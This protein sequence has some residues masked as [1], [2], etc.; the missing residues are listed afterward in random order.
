MRARLLRLFC[1]MLAVALPL[2]LA[3]CDDRA[4]L[5]PELDARAATSGPTVNAPSG[6]NAVA[7]SWSQINLSWQDNSSN[8]S[9]FEVHRSTSGPSGAFTLLYSTAANVTSYS[10]GGLSGSTQYCYKVRASRTAGGKTSYS[11]FS[12]TACATTPVSPLPA[13]PSAVHAAPFDNWTI[14]ITWTDNSTNEAGF[15]V[16]RGATTSGPWTAAFT[17]D[18][19]TTGFADWTFAIYEQAVCYRVFAVNRYGDSN[20][21]NVSCTAIPYPPTNLTATP[22]AGP[23]V[24]LAWTDNSAVEDGVEVL[25]ATSGA[26]WSTIARLPANATAYHDASTALDNTYA[27]AVRATKDGGSSSP[28]NSVQVVMPATKLPAAPSGLGVQPTSSSSVYVTWTDQSSNETGFRVERSTDGGASWVPVA[29]TGVDESSFN[30]QAVSAEQQV[31]YRAIAFNSIGDSPPSNTACTTAPA[32]PTNL[33]GIVRDDGTIEVRWTDNSAVEDGYEVWAL[34]YSGD[35]YLLDIVP[36]NTTSYIL[37]APGYGNYV[38]AT[39]DG[40]HSDPSNPWP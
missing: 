28:S 8:E 37:P 9:G 33:T 11:S 2:Y 35:Y 32:G 25:R 39:K 6:T 30:D 31:C 16:E 15:R 5:A 29:S 22:V 12:N 21:S 27:Y 26:G 24:D 13:T 34:S 14:V 4:L 1:P 20:P 18:S 36:A 3:A 10:N 19:N 38:V 23:S 40:G 7:V 17:T